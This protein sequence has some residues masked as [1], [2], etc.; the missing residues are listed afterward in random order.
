MKQ[1]STTTRLALH[2]TTV[3]ARLLF[4]RERCQVILETKTFAPPDTSVTGSFKFTLFFKKYAKGVLKFYRRQRYGTRITR[5]K[6]VI[7]GKGNFTHLHKPTTRKAYSLRNKSRR[8]APTLRHGLSSSMIIETNL[9]GVI[10]HT[11]C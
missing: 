1:M 9:L 6:V 2:A 11:Y 3:F 4:Q 7:H 8:P 10:Y 5:T